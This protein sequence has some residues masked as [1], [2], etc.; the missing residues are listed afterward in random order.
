VTR[1]R[2]DRQIADGRPCE[3]V[4]A[5]ALRSRQLT[6][7]DNRRRLARALRSVA[8]SCPALSTTAIDRAGVTFGREALLGLA[9]GL[10]APGP[11]SPMGVALAQALLTDGVGSPLFNFWCEPTA[12]H[13]V[14]NV[15][16]VLVADSRQTVCE[17]SRAVAREVV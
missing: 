3:S 6:K 4:P 17:Q 12:V 8:K 15:A 13:A 10:E 9:D 1:G 16:E 7:T 2:L 11:V 14:W 5:L